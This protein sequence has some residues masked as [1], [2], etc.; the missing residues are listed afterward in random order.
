MTDECV[1]PAMS[2]ARR[3]KSAQMSSSSV[4]MPNLGRS[5]TQVILVHPSVLPSLIVGLPTFIM[6]SLK[7][8]L[9]FL[10]SLASAVSTMNSDEKM[11][12]SFAP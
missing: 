3:V 2:Y 11:L 1:Q 7:T 5:G 10:P 4:S 9:N 12:A 6:L 8:C